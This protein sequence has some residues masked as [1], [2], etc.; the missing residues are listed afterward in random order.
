MNLGLRAALLLVVGG[1]SFTGGQS[2]PFEKNP[3]IQ[4]AS[5]FV[6]ESRFNCRKLRHDSRKARADSETGAGDLATSWARDIV[7]TVQNE[8]VAISESKKRIWWFKP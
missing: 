2:Q 7:V 4:L 6:R 8:S 5:E 1:G 3:R